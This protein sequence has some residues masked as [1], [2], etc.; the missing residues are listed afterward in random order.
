MK[1]SSDSCELIKLT[2]LP[3]LLRGK[4]KF[5]ICSSSVTTPSSRIVRELMPERQIFLA[6]S[7]PRPLTP[8]SN[9]SADLNLKHSNK[10]CKMYHC[11][12]LRLLTFLEIPLPTI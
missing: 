1:N 6:T 12:E 10:S 3:I 11:K 4:K 8:I 7:D 5:F 9:T 2:L